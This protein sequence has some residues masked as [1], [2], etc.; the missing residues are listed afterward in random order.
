MSNNDAV[1]CPLCEGQGHMGRRQILELL[2]NPNLADKLAHYGEDIAQ[3]G[4]AMAGARS[5]FQKEVHSWNPQMPIW[6]RSPKE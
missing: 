4:A 2:G 6:R 1:R 5:D 3:E